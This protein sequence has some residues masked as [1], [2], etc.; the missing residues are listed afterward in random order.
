MFY[1]FDCGSEFEEPATHYESREF[2]GAPVQEAF[3]ACP[4]CG[5][6]DYDKMERCE[7]C[8]EWVIDYKWD[9][10]RPVYLCSCCYDDLYG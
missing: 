6:T 3:G 1:C 9:E 7:R 8:G 10:M 5:S 2:W 4:V